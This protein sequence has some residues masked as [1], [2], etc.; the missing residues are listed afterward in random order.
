MQR[1]CCRFGPIPEAKCPGTLFQ[2][3]PCQTAARD[4][5]T[6][7]FPSTLN[8]Q[9]SSKSSFARQMQN[10]IRR[11]AFRP[12]PNQPLPL[13]QLRKR[14]APVIL[15]DRPILHPMD[16]KCRDHAFMWRTS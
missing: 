10:S 5:A 11:S 16:A 13:T 7:L 3:G 8:S 15:V 1:I 6:I 12:L 14:D 4:Q 9:F 2:V